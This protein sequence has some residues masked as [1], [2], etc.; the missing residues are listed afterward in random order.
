MNLARALQVDKSDSFIFPKTASAR[1]WMISGG[2]E[3]ANSSKEELTGKPGQAFQGGWLGL[4]SFG[5]ATYVAVAIIED[6]DFEAL[7]ETLAAHFVSAYGAPSLEAARPVAYAELQHMVDLCNEHE[8]NTILT[9]RRAFSDD[10]I[11][12]TFH[13][14]D[15][16]EVEME[17][18]GAPS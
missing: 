11:E 17:M 7:I 13:V 2:F 15:S 1:E 4:E 12:E 10:G 9:V 16:P 3:F 18:Q 14:I 5:R 6:A 8:P